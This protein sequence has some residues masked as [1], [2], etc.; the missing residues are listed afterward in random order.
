MRIFRLGL[1]NYF[2]TAPLRYRLRDLLPSRVKVIYGSPAQLNR[3]IAE[4]ELEAGLVSSLAYA[5]HHR[6]L[7]LLPDLSISA[8]GRVGSVLLFFRGPLRGL[9]ERTVAVTPESAT[10][11]ALLKLLL[12]DF[13]GLSPRYRSGPPGS[14]EAGYLAIGDEALLLRRNPPF[15]EVLDLAGVWMERTGLPFVFAVLAVHRRAVELFSELIGPL[16]GALYLSRAY[17][18]AH[19]REIAR[20]CPSALT[21]D[22]ALGYLLGLEYDLSGL[23]Q[24]ALRVFFRHLARRGEISRPEDLAF[25]ELP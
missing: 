1:V 13:Y 4:G 9:S 25:V 14:A 3:L 16:A 23:K 19:L 22:E 24:E 18:L 20:R 15:P 2:N 10:S 7:L 12:E 5:K 21:P 11:V 8:T 17:G 6:D